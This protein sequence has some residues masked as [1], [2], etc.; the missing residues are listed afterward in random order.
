MRYGQRLRTT[1]EYRRLLAAAFAALLAWELVAHLIADEHV[2]PTLG[3]ALGSFRSLSDFWEGGAGVP[4]PQAGG[5]ETLE[6]AAL[7]LLVNGAQTALRLLIGLA[8]AFIVG[9]GLGLV[10]GFAPTVRRFAY[11]P[12]IAASLLPTLAL[13]PLFELWFGATMRGAVFFI[14]FGGTVLIARMTVNAVQ[15]VPTVWVE[16]A[17]MLGAS[18]LKIYRTV[19]IPAIVPELRGAVSLALTVCWTLALGGELLGLQSGLGYL[20]HRASQ[21]AKL[22]QMVLISGIYVLLAAISV[23]AFNA[24]ADR[25]IR[26]TD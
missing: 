9:T 13:L 21:L 5:A 16:T 22:D 4:V 8:A 6:G 11:A 19:V 7:V 18:R 2:L 25:F 23:S 10:I 24:L 26:W 14:A 1:F 20:L 3:Q 17:R 12:I 15:N